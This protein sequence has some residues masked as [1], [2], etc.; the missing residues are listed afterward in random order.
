MR[1]ELRETECTHCP[2]D[3]SGVC[4]CVLCVCVCPRLA[5]YCV[6]LNE[7]ACV[8]MCVIDRDAFQH[9]FGRKRGANL[10]CAT[11]C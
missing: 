2:G 6:R 1:V 10:K 7:S 9:K 5:G 11:S 4:V 8:C 3:F